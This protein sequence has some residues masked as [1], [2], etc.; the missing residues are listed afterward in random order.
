MIT[1]QIDRLIFLTVICLIANSALAAGEK[2]LRVVKFDL[3]LP[4]SPVAAEASSTQPPDK[5]KAEDLSAKNAI[6]G[7]LNTRWSSTPEEP[8]WLVVD[9]GDVYDIDKVIISWGPGYASSYKIELSEDRI[10]WKEAYSTETGRGKVDTI[11]FPIEKIGFIK[12]DCIKIGGEP[13]LSIRE[14]TVYGK[15]KLVLF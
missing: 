9:L 4:V 10:N 11:T 1:K 6:D 8:Q 12:I 14:V 5:N 15:K 13:G 7:N 3:P 2:P